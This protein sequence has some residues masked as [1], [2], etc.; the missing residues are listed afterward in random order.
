MIGTGIA[1]IAFLWI[2]FA[3]ANVLLRDEVI[4]AKNNEIEA[5]GAVNQEQTKDIE[6]LQGTVM[7][8]TRD[9]EER[10]DYLQGLIENDPTGAL[11]SGDETPQPGQEEG[12]MQGPDLKPQDPGE[13][14]KNAALVPAKTGLMKFLVGSANAA[15]P[16]MTPREFEDFIFSRLDG[17]ASRQDEIA[18]QLTFFAENKVMETDDMLAP[19]RI[20][21]KDLARAVTLDLSTLGKGGPNFPDPSTGA[22]MFSET[23]NFSKVTPYPVLHESWS[24]MVQVYSGWQSV[25]LLYPVKDFYLSSRF[26][27]RTDPF[28][29][30]PGWHPGVDLAGWP[31]TPI[32]ATSAGIVT[33]AGT[34]STYGKMVEVDH[35]NGFKTRYAH[36]RKVK[37]KRGQMVQPGDILGEM[38]CT[39]R[40]IST[41]LH[42]EVFFNN[43]L[44]NPLPFMEAP[45][46]VQ[47]TKREA[48][49][50]AGKG[51]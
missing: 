8:K 5:L 28:T 22:G 24:R 21:A 1:G 50:T 44:R 27:R 42:Y 51:K 17:I 41:H 12:P 4:E 36:L 25:P 3:S 31:G 32:E 14:D 45:E 34:W 9:L 26:G 38:G 46:D 43:N 35:G 16:P 29:K 13:P 40:C 30:K 39:G 37:V 49:A 18:T 6:R 23:S 33:K 2:A 10:S 11:T 48:L 7:D 19:F 47:Q 20:K 15:T